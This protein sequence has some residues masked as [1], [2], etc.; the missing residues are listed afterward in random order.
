MTKKHSGVH[1]IAMSADYR[2]REATA[3]AVL[4]RAR[5]K[6]FKFL[7]FYPQTVKSSGGK[8]PMKIEDGFL[9][10][11]TLQQAVADS[12]IYKNQWPE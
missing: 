4:V 3:V 2:Q 8:R 10:V 6:S 5:I 11:T 7:F 1:F 12:K 9:E